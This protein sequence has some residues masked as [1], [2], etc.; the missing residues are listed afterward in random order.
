M[1][2]YRNIVESETAPNIHDLWL[3]ADGIYKFEN[4]GWEPISKIESKKQEDSFK[5][6]MS[7]CTDKAKE[8]REE[9]ATTQ[10]PT[11]CIVNLMQFEGSIDAEHQVDMKNIQISSFSN[12]GGSITNLE[13]ME[14]KGYYTLSTLGSFFISTRGEET[15]TTCFVST[16]I[17]SPSVGLKLGFMDIS[18]KPLKRDYDIIPITINASGMYVDCYGFSGGLDN[19]PLEV[20][21]D[22]RLINEELIN[23]KIPIVNIVTVKKSE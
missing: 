17:F 16:A 9:A 5:Y 13:A 12:P 4:N 2:I 19:S 11:V 8:L 7:L 6:L 21:L 18:H 20:S 10:Y 3:K 15:T 14:R 23:T 22:L 1:N